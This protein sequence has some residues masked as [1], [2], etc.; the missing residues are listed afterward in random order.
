MEFRR[1][2]RAYDADVAPEVAFEDLTLSQFLARS[3]SAFPSRPAVVFANGRLT[4]AAFAEQVDRLATAL[5]ALGVRPESRVAV[6]LPNLPQF[7]IAYY[8]ILALGARPVPTNPLYTVREIEYQWNDAGCETAVTADYLYAAR[9]AGAEARL[10]VRHFV[11]ATIP[12]Y[13]RFP[14]NLL[15]PLKLRRARPQPLVARVPR[16]THIHRFRD[17][18]R[19]HE[20]T[21]PRGEP[22]MDDIATLLYTGGTTGLSKGAMLTHRNLSYNVQQ[23]RAW[24]PGLVAGGEVMLTVLP[25]FH[26]YGLTVAM[27][28]GIAMGATLVLLP[29]PRDIAAMVE[30]IARH[31]VT[32]A[33]AV[34]AMYN[35]VIHHPRIDS[36][37][38]ASV[39]MCNSGSAPLP[40][41]VLHEFERRTGAKITEGFGLT[42]TSPVTHSNPF[43][44]RKVGSIGV[45]LPS[46]DA[47]IVD[48]GDGV[49]EVRP[50]M[51]GEL[52]IRGPQ[53]MPGYW[54]K[55]DATADIL[56]DGWLYTADLGR[57]DDDGF[58]FIVGRK[59]DML[60]CSGYNVYPDEIDRVLMAHPAIQEAA[61]IGIPDA[62][63]GETPKSFVVVAAGQQLSA[64]DVMTY[65]RENLA[66]YKVPRFVEFRPELPKSSVLKIL[67]REL[68]AQELAKSGTA[69]H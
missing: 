49:T 30:A 47:K 22:G 38:I 50:G 37:D 62:K 3:A 2:H 53:V 64:E 11:I 24:M 40:V 12:E 29:N 18:I 32:L 36:L 48:V 65:C 34:P 31:R 26:S 66:V 42:E 20:P 57:M 67:R 33:P 68:R 60:I 35:A 15:A 4:Y 45:P 13:L 17:L 54:N 14:L 46:T 58:F 27:N 63:R 52:L 8:A 19:R 61:T 5:A 56:R 6:H 10:P 21:P 44:T 9:I 39:K 16:G 1:W 51:E 25:L 41:D 43:E 23:L 69:M 55:P 28:N 59:K 7:V